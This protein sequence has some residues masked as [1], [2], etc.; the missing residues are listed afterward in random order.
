MPPSEY[1]LIKENLSFNLSLY[2]LFVKTKGQKSEK[3]GK[4]TGLE[5]ILVGKFAE[6]I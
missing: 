6:M 1:S 4:N 3:M 5:W 2:I